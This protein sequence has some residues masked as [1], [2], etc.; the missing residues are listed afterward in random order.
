VTFD[1]QRLDWLTTA[2]RLA[3][4]RGRLN[5]EGGSVR[6]AIDWFMRLDAK[7]VGEWIHTTI[8]NEEKLSDLIRELSIPDHERDVLVDL[9][10]QLGIESHGQLTSC[11]QCGWSGR[12]FHACPGLP[13]ENEF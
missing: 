5:N 2:D 12:Y 10:E 1:K 3:D 7:A 8:Q 13:G 11:T 9:L 6:D 4:V